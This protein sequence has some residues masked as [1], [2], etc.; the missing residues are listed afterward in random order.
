MGEE[1]LYEALQY[2]GPAAARRQT[3]D[4]LSFLGNPADFANQNEN[5][6]RYIGVESRR[7]EYLGEEYESETQSEKSAPSRRQSSG[8]VMQPSIANPS[9]NPFEVQ[10]PVN[11]YPTN[12]DM[13]PRN[14][15]AGVNP[16]VRRYSNENANYLPYGRPDGR[17]IHPSNRP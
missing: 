4:N 10:S 12:S 9:P 1:P 15:Q 8:F 3:G 5:F 2:D 11:S 17:V 16:P 6:K 14:I 7:V 13:G